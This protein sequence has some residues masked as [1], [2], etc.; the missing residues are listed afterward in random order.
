MLRVEQ[1]DS[2]MGAA[3]DQDLAKAEARAIKDHPWLTHMSNYQHRHI[4][5]VLWDL[6]PPEGLLQGS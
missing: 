4:Q 1:V 6:E 2:G 3:T 5:L